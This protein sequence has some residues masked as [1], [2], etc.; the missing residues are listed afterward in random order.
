VFPKREKSPPLRPVFFSSKVNP[1]KQ[2][3]LLLSANVAFPAENLQ[4]L[5]IVVYGLAAAVSAAARIFFG[6]L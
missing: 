5:T 3:L 6:F 1:T 4:N 2:S